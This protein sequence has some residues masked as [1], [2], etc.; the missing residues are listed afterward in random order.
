MHNPL[1][2]PK[3]KGLVRMSKV[4]NRMESIQPRSQESSRI[5]LGLRVKVT[6]VIL[7]P[8]IVILVLS[9]VISYANQRERALESMSLIASQAGEIIE[10]ALQS[11]MLASNFEGIQQTFDKISED[12]RIRTLYLL[13]TQGT[14]IFAPSDVPSPA[15]LDNQEESCQPCHSLPP[16]ERPSG[17]VVAGSEGELV[18]RSMHPI[19]N[20]AECTNCHDPTQRLNGLLL[21]DFSIAPVEAALASDLK[22]NLLWWIGSVLVMAIMINLA[23]NRMVV[24]RLQRLT[25]AVKDFGEKGRPPELEETPSDELGSLSAA[26]NRMA[27]RVLNREQENERLSHELR[28]RIHERGQLLN[29]ILNTQEEERQ[30]VA[31]ELHDEMGQTL[32]ST[33][34][35]I[36]AARR[37]LKSNPEKATEH[38]QRAHSL[39]EESSDQLYEMIVSLR[40]SA[41]DDLGLEAALH[42]LAERALAPLGIEFQLEKETE[43]ERLPTEVET[44]LFRIFQEALTNV[45]RHA[46]ASFVSLQLGCQNGLV[47]GIIEDDG[48]GFD[49]S[50]LQQGLKER[51][52]GLVGMRERVEAA[53]G[54]LQIYS[55]EGKGTRVEVRIPL[56]GCSDG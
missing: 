14:V 9:S 20:R 43:L 39:L 15:R 19:E 34:L 28:R 22:N 35:T 31:R 45:Q 6:L 52:F 25:S 47:E 48:V 49:T 30:R 36:E 42:I 50:I 46:E 3:P 41:L 53:G 13:D 16:A 7:V 38:L 51:G 18:F 10:F 27:S 4:S 11:D 12:E 37:L 8:M 33:S 21:T 55:Q 44:A 1:R 32:S 56:E 5:T 24:D 2:G 40:P 26:F 17:I 23:L 29:K 54:E